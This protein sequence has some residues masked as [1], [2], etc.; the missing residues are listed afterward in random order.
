MNYLDERDA[1][2]HIIPTDILKKAT[3][4]WVKAHEVEAYGK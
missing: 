3:F 2:L 4:K 1:F